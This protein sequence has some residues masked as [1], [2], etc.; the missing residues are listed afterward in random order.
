MKTPV[1]RTVHRRG[2][3]AFLLAGAVVAALPVAAAADETPIDPTLP[4]P[5]VPVDARCG[6][7]TSPAWV[8]VSTPPPAGM[9]VSIG[10]PR[11]TANGVT[12]QGAVHA[13]DAD[14]SQTADGSVSGLPVPSQSVYVPLALA[15]GHAY[16]WYASTYDG[17][18]YSNP[19][20]PCYLSVD[21]SAPAVPSVTDPDFPPVGSPGT[22]TKA[23]GQATTFSFASGETLPEG[24]T[25]AGS[26][27]CRASGLD[28]FLYALDQEPGMGAAQVPADSAGR[29]SLTTSLPWG[30]HTLYVVGVDAA[31]NRSLPSGYTMSVPWQLPP[32]SVPTL[33]LSAPA[34]SGRTAQLHVSGALSAAPYTSGEAVHVVRKDLAHPEGVPLPDAPLSADG[35]FALTDTPQVGGAN[36]Y[37]VTY[38]GDSTHAA[39]DASAAVQVSRSATAVSLSTDAPSYTYGATAK[40][41]AHLGTT[42]NGRVLALYA[43]PYGGEKTL[44]T[45]GTVDSHGNLTATYRL[46]HGTTFTASFAG[47]YRYA[48][49]TA[50][51]TATAGAKVS[52]SLSGYYTDTHYGSVLYR[53]YHHTARARLT[54]TVTPGKAGQCVRFQTQRYYSGAWHTRSTSACHTL[55][56]D[57]DG[58]T[59]LTLTG[60]TDDKL[61]M[62]A[63]Y[64]HSTK[65]TGN[66]STWGSWQ[67]L[68]VRK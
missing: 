44:V 57:S 7:D 27:D 30:T 29:G 40:I 67:Y 19:S 26:P 42:Y 68:T 13:W 52:E 51:R 50:S 20:A 56:A 49:A 1:N 38:P 11:P 4:T 62:R 58:S 37:T 16:G 65:D 10:I 21:A 54:A 33:T 46:T 41:T 45:T 61:R 53:V 12:Y 18:A 14:G 17:T 24:C 6:T 47:D 60:A 64:V 35:T 55:T 31:G 34:T 9:S 15:D 48:P 25:E 36:T 2:L 43:Q 66:L 8:T 5:T 22:P 39:V 3:L 23:A 63:E 28:H 32:P 59:T